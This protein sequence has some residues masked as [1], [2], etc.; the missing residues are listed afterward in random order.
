MTKKLSARV[1]YALMLSIFLLMTGFLGL[2]IRAF[3]SKMVS[4]STYL[5]GLGVLL[6]ILPIYFIRRRTRADAAAD[7]K[8]RRPSAAWPVQVQEHVASGQGDRRRPLLPGQERTVV[9][10][11]RR[12]KQLAGFRVA[13][14]KPIASGTL[15]RQV[16]AKGSNLWSKGY[17]RRVASSDSTGERETRNGPSAC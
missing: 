10:F 17:Q 3:A 4:D 13:S 1:S 2:G 12:S 16:A 6:M 8:I 7:R 5:G 15:H 9:A 14:L 11:E